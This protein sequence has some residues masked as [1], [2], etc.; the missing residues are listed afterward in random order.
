VGKVHKSPPAGPPDARAVYVDIDPVAVAARPA[1]LAS[2]TGLSAVDEVDGE[3]HALF[4][5]A[6]EQNVRH[7]TSVTS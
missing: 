4:R 7:A 2:A 1:I 6:Y 3:V 5:P